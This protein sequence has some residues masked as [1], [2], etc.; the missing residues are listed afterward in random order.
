MDE[1]GLDENLKPFTDKTWS[2]VVN[3]ASVRSTLQSDKYAEV[4]K[5]IL[6]AKD[7]DRGCGY[8]TV[9]YRLYTAVKRPKT[10]PKK[11]KKACVNTRFHSVLPK[12]NKTGML[13]DSCIFCRKARKVIKG[14]NDPKRICQRGDGTEA[15]YLRAEYS[16]N[17]R[18]KSL[19]R[20]GVKLIEKRSRVS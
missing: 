7:T 18:I 2:T 1:S 13:K 10:T 20:S 11:R 14:I 15:I 6:L 16:K 4:T 8:H 19:V 12:S 3:A 5:Q 17:D 9:C